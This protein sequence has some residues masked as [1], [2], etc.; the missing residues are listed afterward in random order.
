MNRDYAQDNPVALEDKNT[1]AEKPIRV[2]QVVGRMMGGGVE[3]T[4]MNHYRHI[5]RSKVQFDFVIQS[6]STVVPREEIESL[7]GRIFVVPPYS[8]PFAY[9][10]ACRKVFEENKPPIVHSH[11]NAISVFTLRAAKQAGVPIRIAHSHSTANP[12]EVIKTIVKN[13]L[14]PFSKMYPTDFAACGEY[15]ARWLFGNRIV[16]K[17]VVH[18]IRNAID[19]KKY[20]YNRFTREEIRSKIGI[21]ET[22][23]LIGQVGRFSTQ[24]NQKYTLRVIKKILEKQNVILVFAGDGDQIDQIKKDSELLKINKSVIFLGITK[25][26]NEWYSAF[27]ILIIPSLY[28]GLPLCMIEA[29]SANLPI[30][31][32]DSITEEAYILT[33]TKRLSLSDDFNEWCNETI[34]LATKYKNLRDKIDTT[35]ILSQKGY[36]IGA[37]AKQLANWYLLLNKNAEM[38]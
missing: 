30:V 7:G 9:M 18:I 1:K 8:N 10:K 11:M 29:Q 3:A 31:G 36:E 21:S 5:D 37:S 20:V 32:S 22:D 15:S 19:L 17:G 28:E 23:L 13:I 24:K 16:D 35:E 14:R 34:S 26:I 38:N 4:V 6:D 27:D 2:M 33:N 12:E 25:N